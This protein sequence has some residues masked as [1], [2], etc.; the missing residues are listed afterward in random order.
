MFNSGLT[1]L[2]VT[3][4][5]GSGSG[6]DGSGTRPNGQNAGVQEA[7]KVLSLRVPR[8]VGAQ[9]LAPSFLLNSQGSGGNP[10]IDSVVNTVLAR[11]FPTGGQAPSNV[12]SFGTAPASEP[13]WTGSATPFESPFQYDMPRPTRRAPSVD[14]IPTT[15]YPSPPRVTP[16]DLPSDR[17]PFENKGPAFETPLP[18]PQPAQEQPS[19]APVDPMEWLNRNSL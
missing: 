18:A 9:A 3:F 17:S 4:Q 2:G 6:S 7:I 11:M 16:G 10:R 1:G 15:R 13:A 14:T 8:V 19:P 5:P 12:P